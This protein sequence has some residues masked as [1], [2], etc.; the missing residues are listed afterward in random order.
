MALSGLRDMSTIEA[1]A[2]GPLSCADVCARAPR[3]A[4]CDEAIR[5]ELCPRRAGLLSAQPRGDPST[6]ARRS[7]K[8]R[9]PE[10]EIAV[11][12]G[13]M[14]EEAA[15]RRHAG[16]CQTAKFRSLS[17]RPSSRRALTSRTSTRSSLR[18]P[19]GWALRSCTRFAGA[20]AVRAATPM[21]YLTFRKGKVLSEIAE[22]RLEHHPRIRGIRL[23]L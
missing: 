18:T 4:F 1:A 2:A 9:I 13:K 21:P 16:I 12:H 22:K 8:Q 15:R 5:R 6:S 19:T 11:A 17:A 14:N 10:A 20:W 7:I 3:T 23:W